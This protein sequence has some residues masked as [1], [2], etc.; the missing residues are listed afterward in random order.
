MLCI[1]DFPLRERTGIL[2]E[3]LRAHGSQQILKEYWE[4]NKDENRLDA[5]RSL[6]QSFV[7]NGEYP[8]LATSSILRHVLRADPPGGNAWFSEIA[9]AA[10]QSSCAT[11][12]E[13]LGV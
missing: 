2:R 4:K 11:G 10:A 5:I 12:K 8:F 3:V 7:T 13:W 6:A 1:M 9:R